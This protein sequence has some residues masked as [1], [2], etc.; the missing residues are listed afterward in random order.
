MNTIKTLVWAVIIA[1]LTGFAFWVVA[2]PWYP[3]NSFVIFL[4]VLFFA[5]PNLGT[6]WM[7]YVSVRYEQRPLPFVV[8]SFVPYAFLWYYFERVR[9]G[10]HKTP[11]E[12]AGGA[13]NHN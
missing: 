13:L 4:L 5:V 3:R 10:R 11:A 9:A 12:N 6:I 2:G 8:L 1:F 7:I